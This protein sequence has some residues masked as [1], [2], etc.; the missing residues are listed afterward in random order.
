MVLIAALF[1]SLFTFT[2]RLIFPIGSSVM[3]MQ[4]CFFPQYILLFILGIFISRKNLLLSIPYRMGIKWF[5][6]TLIFGTIFWFMMLLI[7]EIPSK[8]FEAFEGHFTWQSAAYST[9]ESFFCFGVCIG[10]IVLFREKFN[11]QGQ[12]GK[13]LSANAF[14]VYVLHAPILIF[15]SMLFKDITLYPFLKY[16]VVIAITVPACFLASFFLRKIPGV[17]YIIK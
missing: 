1:L 13:F 8:G 16:L 9:W 14:G 10:L 4:L 12:I 3:N 2:T 15:I 6:Y 5:R 11:R 7:G 17:D